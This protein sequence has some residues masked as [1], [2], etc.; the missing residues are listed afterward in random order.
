MGGFLVAITMFVS[1]AANYLWTN[2]DII[3]ADISGLVTILTSAVLPAVNKLRQAYEERVG[4]EVAT[5]FP[6]KFTLEIEEKPLYIEVAD[7]ESAEAVLLLAQRI[8]TE[9][10][11]MSNKAQHSKLKTSV[12]T[13]PKRKRR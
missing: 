11:V 12:P 4:K 2:K 1:T 9:H 7:L 10:P 13:L 5:K 3:I 6:L 8:Y